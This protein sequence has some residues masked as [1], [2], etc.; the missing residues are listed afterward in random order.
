MKRQIKFRGKLTNPYS[1]AAWEYGYLIVDE[2]G[3]T[4]IMS[5][6][7]NVNQY[8]IE[9]FI[10]EVI[11]ETVGQFTGIKDKNGKEIY[12]GD[13]VDVWSQGS[14]LPNGIIKWGIGSC[15]FFIGNSSDS[16]CWNLSGRYD[17]DS[18]VIVI[19]NIY[20]SP[21]LLEL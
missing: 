1:D 10:L 16:L 2:D 14:H 11:P 13:I 15:R 4:A 17:M 6:P 19:G 5:T 12:E 8:S 3:K 20:D 9:D 7:E 21:E 18:G